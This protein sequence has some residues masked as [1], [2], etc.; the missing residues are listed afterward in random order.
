MTPT[1]PQVEGLG[2]VVNKIY[3]YSLD[4]VGLA[5]FIMFLY[6]GLQYIFP[7]SG[8]NAGAKAKEAVIDA[9]VGAVLLFSAYVILNTVN[10]DL[11]SRRDSTGTTQR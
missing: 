1:L 8:A 11:V 4:I 5:V 7:F 2:Q 9:I 3:V 6:A 10:K